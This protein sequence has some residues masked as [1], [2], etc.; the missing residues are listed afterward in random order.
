MIIREIEYTIHMKDRDKGFNELHILLRSELTRFEDNYHKSDKSENPIQVFLQSNIERSI[1]IRNNTKVYFLNYREQGSL[2]ITFT[3]LV[4]SNPVNYISTRQTL[5][6][7]VKNTIGEYFEE[8]LERHI[9][10]SVAVM[11]TERELSE[12]SEKGQKNRESILQS[13][14]DF[15]PILLASVAL[16]F[17]ISIGVIFLFQKN[18][19]LQNKVPAGEYKDKYYELLIK[20]Q[21]NEAIEQKLDKT[22][23]RTGNLLTSDTVQNLKE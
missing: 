20:Q 18:Q 9:P 21:V 3:I 8:L 2:T 16:F 10:V 11:A 23:L 6:Y 1:V 5:D 13:K 12:L 14:Y 4:I 15:L 7:L 19:S 22:H 17:T